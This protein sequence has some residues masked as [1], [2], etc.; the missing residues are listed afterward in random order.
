[1][2]K[3]KGLLKD[4]AEY[5]KMF[6]ITEKSTPAEKF[7]YRI[8]QV[9]NSAEDWLA[10]QDEVIAYI[11]SKPPQEEIRILNSCCEMLEMVCSAI[12]ED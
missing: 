9:N 10:L 4:I 1:M 6:A 12:R 5:K 3:V 8:T 7:R 2:D 11:A